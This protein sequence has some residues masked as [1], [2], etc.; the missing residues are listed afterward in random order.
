MLPRILLC[1]PQV[2][3]CGIADSSDL[4]GCRTVGEARGLAMLVVSHNTSAEEATSM[5]D[6]TTMLF[7]L[8]ESTVVDDGAVRV[9]IEARAGEGACPPRGDSLGRPRV[10]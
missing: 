6:R 4:T 1:C 3:V 10:G 2:S 7:G 5:D 9:M 8:D